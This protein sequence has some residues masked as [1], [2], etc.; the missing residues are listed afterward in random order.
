MLKGC[1]QLSSRPRI[2]NI[3]NAV[4]VGHVTRVAV[5]AS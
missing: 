4:P 5:V 3:A 2:V 1:I